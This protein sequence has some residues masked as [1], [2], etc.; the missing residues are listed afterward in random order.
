MSSSAWPSTQVTNEEIAIDCRLGL[1][2]GRPFSGVTACMDFCAHAHKDQHN[3]YNGC[4][5]VR[6]PVSQSHP[7]DPPGRGPTG[8]CT[9]VGSRRAG[10]GDRCSDSGTALAGRPCLLTSLRKL[11]RCG[12]RPGLVS[13]IRW[14]LQNTAPWASGASQFSEAWF[15]VSEHLDLNPNYLLIH[16]LRKCLL[17]PGTALDARG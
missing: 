16:S 15:Q 5:V 11:T 4:T 17:C 13:V 9:L 7:P 10:P 12:D 1:K 8:L 14:V 2:E 3:L 6:R